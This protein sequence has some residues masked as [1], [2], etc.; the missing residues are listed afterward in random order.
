MESTTD[1]RAMPYTILWRPIR[2]RRAD[3]T[4]RAVTSG[5]LDRTAFQKRLREMLASEHCAVITYTIV[6]R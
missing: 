4:S 1:P 3:W 5:F 6:D 2:D